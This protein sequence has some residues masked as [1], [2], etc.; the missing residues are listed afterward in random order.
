[1]SDPRVRVM[2]YDGQ[3]LTESEISDPDDET[4]I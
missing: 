3:S 4:W 2:A 1:M